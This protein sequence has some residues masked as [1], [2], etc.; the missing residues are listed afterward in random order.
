VDN[1]S[2]TNIIVMSVP[3]RHDLEINSCINQ[4]VNEYNKKLKQ[5]LQSFDNVC[6]IDVDT[7]RDIFTKHGLHLN[8][9]GKERMANMIVKAVKTTLNKGKSVHTHMKNAEDS[10]SEKTGTKG[11]ILTT[12][13][14]SENK[15]HP[16][17]PRGKEE[18]TAPR[19][20]KETTEKSH[21]NKGPLKIP[22]HHPPQKKTVLSPKK[23]RDEID[24]LESSPNEQDKSDER[25]NLK[26]SKPKLGTQNEQQESEDERMQ[27]VV[28][29]S[30]NDAPTA[31]MQ[32]SSDPTSNG[33]ASGTTTELLKDKEKSSTIPIPSEC[34]LVDIKE[35]MRQP[36]SVINAD[37]VNKSSNL[38]NRVSSS[39]PTSKG[40]VIGPMTKALREEKKPSTIP[41]PSEDVL[42]D[43]KEGIRQPINIV[44]VI[45]EDNGNGSSYP[46]NKMSSRRKKTPPARGDD[47]LWG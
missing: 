42:F 46:N 33:N 6:I 14:T 15:N 21:A 30:A 24:E 11:E 4:E 36:I 20:T 23:R 3:H 5:L 26:G 45:N 38:N 43:I 7:D 37:N 22:V 2:E 44:N 35:G 41:I 19:P 29:D 8:L 32:S 39:D 25:V 47:F 27:N 9:K 40:N 10:K 18:R 16:T 28:L 1:H 12:E 31:W 13:S 34:V 17:V